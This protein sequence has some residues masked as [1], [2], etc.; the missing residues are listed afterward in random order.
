[1]PTLTP[2]PIRDASATRRGLVGILAQTF[3]GVKTFLDAIKLASRTTGTLPAGGAELEGQV[4]YNTSNKRPHVHVGTG[5]VPVA[6]SVSSGDPLSLEEH[7]VAS[8][9]HIAANIGFDDGNNSW[10]DGTSNGGEDVQGALD[11]TVNTLGSMSGALKIGVTTGSGV[12]ATN[13]QAGLVEAHARIAEKLTTSELAASTGT[14]LVGGAAKSG[15][16]WF[17]LA[18]GT[19][20]AQVEELLTHVNTAVNTARAD[21][22]APTL[23]TLPTDWLGDLTYAKDNG[24]WGHVLG[25]IENGTGSPEGFPF[26]VGVLPVGVR[27]TKPV[28]ACGVEVDLFG[29]WTGYMLPI[30]IT[31]DGVIQVV[32]GIDADTH[33]TM[34]FPAYKCA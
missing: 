25:T 8:P 4:V 30:L 6:L 34:N 7:L 3:S 1:M 23:V 32:A 2:S 29:G 22:V 15:M 9:A 31:E 33:V 12:T 20:K 10:R 28:W 11:A 21:L 16:T 5:W 26:I 17:Q 24:G 27:P 18:A 13:V 19:L 14:T